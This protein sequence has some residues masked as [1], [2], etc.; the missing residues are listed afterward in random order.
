M[1]RNMSGNLDLYKYLWPGSVYLYRKAIFRT[2]TL[3]CQLKLSLKVGLKL[4]YTEL[5]SL[6]IGYNLWLCCSAYEV[7]KNGGGGDCLP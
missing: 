2:S 7:V 4:M 6:D 5:P 3:Y 1:R